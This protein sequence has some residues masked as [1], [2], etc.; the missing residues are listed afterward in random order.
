MNS[1]WRQ[2]AIACG[3][4]SLLG[5]G[6]LLLSPLQISIVFIGGWLL[7]LSFQRPEI[8][9]IG[10]LTITSSIFIQTKA[11]SISLGF[12][13]I[14]LTDAILILAF[15]L[16]IVRWLT[17]SDFTLV[18]TPLDWALILFLGASLLSTSIA[19]IKGNLPFRQS[20]GEA[21]NVASY[22]IFFIVTNLVRDRRQL[23]L[24]INGLVS[25]GA[26]VAIA[27]IVQYTLGTSTILIPGRVEFVSRSFQA[28][29]VIPPG[30]S[31]LIVSFILVF[32]ALIIDSSKSINVLR[33]ILCGLIG[34][35]I[36]ITFFRAS[37]IALVLSIGFMGF[38][39]GEK[40]RRRLLLIILMILLSIAFLIVIA[41]TFWGPESGLLTLAEDALFRFSTLFDPATYF[42]P[43]SSL[44]WRDFEYKNALPQIISKPFTGLGLG[45]RYR[46]FTE[47]DWEE[48]DGRGY[49]HNGFIW[50]LMKTGLFGILG[51]L[52]FLIGVIV[53]GVR[54]WKNIPDLKYRA[55]TLASMLVTIIVI[56]V[57]NVEP[58]VMTDY[59]TPVIG[60]IAGI[61]EVI[62]LRYVNV[63]KR[64]DKKNAKFD[65]I[66]TKM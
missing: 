66:E 45:A 16:I 1:F 61:N 56:V 35:S 13:T 5:A 10:Y 31:L 22:L 3:F 55:F 40:K 41:I 44:R 21:R 33:F 24:L 51:V 49:I 54:H 27:T 14:Y 36:I 43:S 11:L 12:G 4:G 62:L 25:L 28:T 48:F 38:L 37:W 42:D 50:I 65:I 26:I 17:E 29:R 52:S 2:L 8:L 63:L 53:R 60:V 15:V 9:V 46:P 7:Y 23:F 58:Y 32:V 39:I 34:V 64:D 19:I 57:S 47:K 18:S 6:L 30:Q 59:W 20:L